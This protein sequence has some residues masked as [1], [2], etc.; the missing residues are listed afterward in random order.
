MTQLETPG[1]I[2]FYKYIYEIYNM[3]IF[4]IYISHIYFIYRWNPDTLFGLSINNTYKSW[5]LKQPIVI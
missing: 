4:H 3:Y 5:W 2:I 1:K